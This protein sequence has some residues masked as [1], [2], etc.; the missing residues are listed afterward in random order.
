MDYIYILLFY[1]N[2]PLK[3]LYGTSH[4]H[5][6]THIETALLFTAIFLSQSYT[7]G[8][9]VRGNS[10]LSFSPKAGFHMVKKCGCPT[11]ITVPKQI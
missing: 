5:P 1:F 7:A 2:R 8:R 11:L 10:G 3:M 6:F 4:M 9:A